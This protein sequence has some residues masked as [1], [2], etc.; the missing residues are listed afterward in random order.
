MKSSKEW[1]SISDMMTGLMMIFLFI[2]ILYMNQ[3][4]K[5]SEKRI[6]ER[7]KET[8][9]S[10]KQINIL[11]EK[12]VV[13]KRTIYEKLKKEFQKDLKKW[14]AEIIENSLIIRFLSPD[15]MFDPMKS[16]IRAEFK[17]ILHDFCPRYFALLYKFRTG[18]EELRVEG[19]TSKEWEGVSDK[20][21]YFYNME[22]SQDRTRSVLQYCTTI[23][24]IEKNINE[25][26]RE[27]L[28]ANGLSSSRPI[29]KD[30]TV[31]CRS[32]N[33]R[34]EFR[35]QINESNVLHKIIKEVKDIFLPK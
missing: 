1:I 9:D 18:I 16:A 19:H 25:W 6:E 30:D 26:S 35:I 12:Y 7:V 24:N 5:D 17:N 33:R 10:V 15:V 11:T 27:K 23:K 3:I 22:L 34:V 2:S 32:L 14:N 21:A 31:R 13:D 29:C 20:E 28:S 4:Q 8:K